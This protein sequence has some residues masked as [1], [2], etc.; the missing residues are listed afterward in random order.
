MPADLPPRPSI[1]HLKNQAKAL[2]RAYRNKEPDAVARFGFLS[3]KSGARPTLA[4]AQRLVAREYGFAS[5]PKL[6]AHVAK[7]APQANPVQLIKEAFE[8]N[9]AEGLRRLLSRHPHL[10]EFV[11]QPICPFDSPP[12]NWVRSREML[13]LLLDAGADINAKSRWWAGGFGILDSVE[14]SLAS[15]AIERGAVITPHAAARL[16]MLDRLRDLI[17]ADPALVDARGGDGQTPLHFASTVEIARFLLE[18][19]ADIDAQDIDH[20]STPAQYMVRDRQ[21]VARFLVDRACKTDLLM[22]AALGDLERVRRHLNQ[23]PD[24]IR[25]AVSERY[26]PKN[27]PRSGGHIYIW[28]LGQNKTPHAIARDFGHTD[29]FDL[30][31]RQ[32]P[33]ELKFTQ[34]C[35]LADQA[36]V[37]AMLQAHPELP[38]SL[39]DVDRQTLVNAAQDNNTPA[40]RLMLHAG[41]PVDARGRHGGTA[42]H[43]AAFHGNAQM[44]RDILRHHPDL[45]DSRNDFHSTPLGWAI[46]GS[47]HGW[48][49]KTG[50]Y[51]ATVQLLCEAGAA[52]P[53]ELSGTEPVKAV[54]GRFSVG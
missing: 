7:L 21:H 38:R 42:L 48:H 46:H 10:K 17:S 52:I 28:T 45:N 6:K 40:V 4:D 50:D 24:S 43:W 33:P 12:I 15:Y 35:A 18:N 34:A 22:A 32:S 16:A 31:M 36:A 53:R 37:A 30:L 51:P 11:N 3:L 41:W 49:R 19:G 2:L 9:D 1:E 47:E 27:N 5:W 44:T 13:D 20:E 14:P 26:F 29:I 8:A 23:D 39:G 54:L 25:M